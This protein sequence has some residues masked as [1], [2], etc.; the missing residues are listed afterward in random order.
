MTINL[1]T[2]QEAQDHLRI[3]DST[4][5]VVSGYIA[6]ASAAIYTYIGDGIYVDPEAAL[7]VVRDD[8]KSA[9][10]LLVGDFY[11]YRE[12]TGADIDSEAYGFLP[13]YVTALL[14]PYR[15]VV[16]A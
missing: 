1:I 7:P 2:L 3:D 15:K 9:C 6:A 13:R 5:P 8:V 12:A 14:F 16:T 11:R 10:K 4:D